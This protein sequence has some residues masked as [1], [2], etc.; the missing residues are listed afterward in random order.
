MVRG[1]FLVCVKRIKIHA[2]TL[3]LP[4]GGSERAEAPEDSAAREL[5]EET[6]IAVPAS[7]MVPM[8]PLAMSPNR[9]PKL[10]YVFRVD[11]AQHEY[12]GRGAHDGEIEKVELLRFDE[13]ARMIATGRIYVSVPVAI[14]GTYLMLRKTIT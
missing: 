14:I 10:I 11:L 13:A 12:D 1:V 9:M 6:G 5:A 3:E 8:P 4:A 7:R 2:T